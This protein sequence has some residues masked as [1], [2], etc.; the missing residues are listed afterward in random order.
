M[1]YEPGPPDSGED[2]RPQPMTAPRAAGG[3]DRGVRVPLARPVVTYVL[4]AAMACVFLLEMLFGGSTSLDT[5][6]LLGAQ[7]NSLIAAGQYWRL[8]SAMFLHIGVAH[9]AFNG[10]ALYILGREVEGT[11]GSVR[12]TAIYFLSGLVGGVTYYV[13]G[14]PITVSAGASGAIFGLFGAEVAYFL[15]NRSLFGSIGR[16]RLI[17]LAT[18]LVINLV[19][20]FTVP[21]INFVVHLGGLAAGLALGFALAPR[22]QVTWAWAGSYPEPRL[23]SQRHAWVELTAVLAAAVLLVGGL[24][25]GAR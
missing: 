21:N 6:V 7:V 3:A 14:P 11:Y 22:Y 19:L 16:R 9:I 17:N 15:I 18:L 25:L 24:W 23:E 2:L 12:F 13:V 1:S 10:Y 5:L 4:L 20:S 8:L